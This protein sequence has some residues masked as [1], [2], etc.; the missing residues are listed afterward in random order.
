MGK[1]KADIRWYAQ[2]QHPSPKLKKEG[3]KLLLEIPV[4][5]KIYADQCTIQMGL[6]GPEKRQTGGRAEKKIKPRKARL[7]P[8]PALLATHSLKGRAQEKYLGLRVKKKNKIKKKKTHP[9]SR[10]SPFPQLCRAHDPSA[11]IIEESSIILWNS[12]D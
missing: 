6:W 9:N 5:K 7:E 1:T 10:W 11:E 4:K 12:F 8:Q 2:C 3:C